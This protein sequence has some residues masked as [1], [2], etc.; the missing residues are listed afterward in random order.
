MMDKNNNKHSLKSIFLS[1]HVVMMAMM[2]MMTLLFLM[3]ATAIFLYS[4]SDMGQQQQQQPQQQL[5][6]VVA[7]LTAS[8]SA[9]AAVAVDTTTTTR[10][11]TSVLRSSSSSSSSN[12]ND[13]NTLNI[14]VI[15]KP[16]NVWS[17]IDTL[18]KCNGII[19][20]PD[21]PVRVF[22]DGKGKVVHMIDGS[23]HYRKMYGSTIFN[24]TR[25]CDISWDMTGNND[26]AMYA[27]NEFLDS[28]FAFHNGTVVSLIHNEYPGNNYNNCIGQAYP[29]CWQVSISL[30]VSYDYGNTW[31]HALEPPN[32]L[33]A[34]VPYKYDNGTLH[35]PANGWGDPSDIIYNPHDNFYYFAIWN[36]NT[37]GKQQPGTCIVRSN[38][39][40]DPKSWKGYGGDGVYNITFISPYGEEPIK[41]I[42]QHLCTV[43]P[44]IKTEC[45]IFGLKYS[46]LLQKFVGTIGCIS[47]YRSRYFY[48]STSNDMI[49]WTNMEPF[50]SRED[51]PDDVWKVT[52]SIH[53]P[54]II[55]PKKPK[56]TTN[57]ADDDEDCDDLNYQ[58]IG[59]T[60]YLFWVSFGHNPHTDGRNLWATPIQIITETE[61]IEEAEEIV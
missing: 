11:S 13:S 50:Y 57:G 17:S 15:G 54:T 37:V 12:D 23:T 39:L 35:Q 52:T 14:T 47:G 42:N 36:R 7:I 41:D 45:T 4:N 60:P 59:S 3:M 19:D 2:M 46:T 51:L 53:Y 30:A 29:Y 58:T 38:D 1:K 40:M 55:D 48:I 25:D 5:Y 43:I 44:N 18:H 10:S 24:V 49:Q 28:T 21:I 56:S 16:I 32:N 20:V 61:L 8:A 34:A 22:A 6:N 31:Q 9:A 26:P 27:A 33:V